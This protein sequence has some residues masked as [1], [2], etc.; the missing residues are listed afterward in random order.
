MTAIVFCENWIELRFIYQLVD[1]VGF[2]FTLVQKKFHL[3]SSIDMC[4]VIRNFNGEHLSCCACA[5]VKTFCFNCPEAG[6]LW[7]SNISNKIYDE[8]I[9]NN[10]LRSYS[11]GGGRTQQPAVVCDTPIST[12][13]SLLVFSIILALL[14]FCSITNFLWWKVKES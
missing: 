3:F 13:P 8:L 7:T 12:W 4:C 1:I 10:C 2:R 5:V 9:A 6:C 14:D 11:R